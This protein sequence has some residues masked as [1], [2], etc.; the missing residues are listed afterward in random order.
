MN[1]YILFLTVS[2]HFVY[3]GTEKRYLT[4]RTTFSRSVTEDSLNGVIN[5]CLLL[6]K[7][8]LTAVVFYFLFLKEF[9]FVLFLSNFNEEMGYTQCLVRVYEKLEIP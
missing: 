3:I 1:F 8:G 5:L 4:W 9:S 2:Q 6:L 7:T